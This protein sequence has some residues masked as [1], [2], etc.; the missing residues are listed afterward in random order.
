MSEK[1]FRGKLQECCLVTRENGYARMFWHY[2]Y[3]WIKEQHCDC[4][5]CVERCAEKKLKRCKN[6]SCEGCKRKADKRKLP[7][8]IKKARGLVG[9]F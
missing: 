4:R 9:V 2:D 1:K 7:L 3:G 5:V 6:K 8:A